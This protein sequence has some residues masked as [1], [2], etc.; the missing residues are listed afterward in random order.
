MELHTFTN[1]KSGSYILEEKP[2]KQGENVF[3]FNFMNTGSILNQNNPM[4]LPDYVIYENNSNAYRAEVNL[5]Y[6]PGS[7]YGSFINANDSL[8][9]FFFRDNIQIDDQFSIDY[10]NLPILTD[11]ITYQIPYLNISGVSLSGYLTNENGTRESHIVHSYGNK[12]TSNPLFFPKDIFDNFR[13]SIFLKCCT[14]FSRSYQ[15]IRFGNPA[16]DV[17]EL[18]IYNA[19]LLNSSLDGFTLETDT[20]HDFSSVLFVDTIGNGNIYDD[21]YY[22]YIHSEETNTISLR[23]EAL[24]NNIFPQSEIQSNDMIFGS[25]KLINNSFE[26]GN[27]SNFI[28]GI[29]EEKEEYPM[30]TLIETGTFYRFSFN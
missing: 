7:F 8:P 22:F 29:I 18:P 21:L 28:Q 9:R 30:G 16:S 5:G 4:G 13:L 6:Y 1:S 27:F 19:S 17:F 20:K 12:T 2:K 26:T 3:R 25:V 23:K 10:Q 15:I 11:K 14:D 24:F